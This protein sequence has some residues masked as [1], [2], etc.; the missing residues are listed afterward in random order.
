MRKCTYKRPPGFVD[1]FLEPPQ[2]VEEVP[3]PPRSSQLSSAHVN[4]VRS[5]K[6]TRVSSLSSIGENDSLDTSQKSKSRRSEKGQDD[7]DEYADAFEED[8]EANKRASASSR[9]A[10]VERDYDG[11]EEDDEFYSE[12]SEER[13]KVDLITI[14]RKVRVVKDMEPTDG[15]SKTHAVLFMDAT[16]QCWMLDKEDV[17]ISVFTLPDA[18]NPESIEAEAEIDLQDL[19]A[20]RGGVAAD[21]ESDSLGENISMINNMLRY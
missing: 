10:D 3:R 19:S 6:Q 2:P 17:V 11:Q 20:I 13:I 5:M 7:Y 18:D 1:P 4:R 16:V 15:K 21:S 9:D 14:N 12:A 8:E